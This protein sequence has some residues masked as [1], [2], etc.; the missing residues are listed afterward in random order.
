[1]ELI[2]PYK[3]QINFLHNIIALLHLAFGGGG[4]GG[5]MSIF[6]EIAV[7]VSTT[8]ITSSFWF[9]SARIKSYMFTCTC[10]SIHIHMM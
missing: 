4:G 1:M 9:E 6:D 2:K 8:D 7:S 10:I 5:K 3:R